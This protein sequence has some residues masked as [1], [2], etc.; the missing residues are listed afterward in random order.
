KQQELRQNLELR[1]ENKP[2]E[3]QRNREPIWIS[4]LINSIYYFI[5]TVFIMVVR[6]GYRLMVIHK[7][8]LLTDKK[9]RT[10]RG[11]RI[12]FVKL[13]GEKAYRDDVMPLWSNFYDPVHRW[14][15]KKL[16]YKKATESQIQEFRGK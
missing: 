2:V 13:W 5:D 14:I 10:L 11:A 6:G 9:Y 8:K 12:G 16:S 15:D 4:L 1:L 7:R 3:G